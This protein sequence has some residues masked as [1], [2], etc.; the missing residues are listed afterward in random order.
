MP[1][2]TDQAQTTTSFELVVPADPELL[3][4]VRLL[5]SGLASFT[6]LDLDTVEAVRVGADELV[7]TLMQSGDGSAVSV[8]FAIHEDRLEIAASTPLAA[9]HSFELDPLTDRILGEVTSSHGFDAEG[10]QLT[11]H[12][13]V[14]LS[15][16]P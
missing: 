8:H 16:A 13:H 1:S 2:S 3:R 4:V 15:K 7:S 10:G 6:P 5:A 9:E 11:G 12:I 14:A